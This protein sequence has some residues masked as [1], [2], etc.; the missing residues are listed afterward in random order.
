MMRCSCCDREQTR[1]WKDNYYCTDC[2][3]AIKDIMREDKY[4]D[5]ERGREAYQHSRPVSEVSPQGLPNS[6]GE[7][8]LLSLLWDHYRKGETKNGV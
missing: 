1:W 6:M 7:K 8:K 3:N 5:K 2:L 4:A